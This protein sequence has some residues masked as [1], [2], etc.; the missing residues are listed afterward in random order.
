M[1]HLKLSGDAPIPSTDEESMFVGK[2]N[3]KGI[4]DGPDSSKNYTAPSATMPAP[5]GGGSYPMPSEKTVPS[6]R[7][8]PPDSRDRD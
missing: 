2:N 5:G 1:A 3:A 8:V 4:P 6:E 7:T